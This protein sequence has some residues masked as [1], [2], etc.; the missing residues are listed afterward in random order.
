MD[1][2]NYRAIIAVIVAMLTFILAIIISLTFQFEIVENLVMSW[3]LTTFY[4]IFGILFIEP[5]IVKQFETP[6]ENRII[7]FVDRPVYIEK[8]VPV[9]VPVQAP[10][11]NKTIKIIEK[12]VP[13]IKK[14]IVYR[15]KKKIKKNIPRIKFLAS[16]ETKTFHKRACRFGKL[17][18]KKYKIQNNSQAFF[19]K[20][21]FKACKVCITKQQ[22]A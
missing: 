7:E 3:I 12:E 18:K 14:V 9:Q 16:T 15:D 10:V 4:A 21:H 5:K 8:E 2:K 20:K 11:E 22:K 13:V 17:I 1:N 6:T 19:K